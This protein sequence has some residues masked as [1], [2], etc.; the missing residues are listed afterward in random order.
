MSIV[1]QPKIDCHCHVIDPVRF[2]YRADSRYLPTGQ[3]VAPCDHF[4]RIM[5]LYGVRHALVVATNSGYGEDLSPVLDALERGEGRLKGVA[6]VAADIAATDLARLKAR[7]MIGVAFNAPF[8]G[9]AHYADTGEL[10][11]KLVDLD[12][13]LQLQVKDD[14]LPAFLPLIERSDV[15]L[16]IDH[17]GRPA[18][19]AALTSLALKRCSNSAVRGAPASSCQ[20]SASSPASAI[21]SQTPTGS[22]PPCSKLSRRMPASGA[23]TGRS[24]GRLN[25]SITGRC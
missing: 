20:V 16:V 21:R 4:E 2:P 5:H 10:L 3:E 8:H 1:T 25:G 9:V 24:C 22:L 6:V 7:G 14:Q 19:S 12:M 13:F 15:R 11:R 23:P 17:C 18:P